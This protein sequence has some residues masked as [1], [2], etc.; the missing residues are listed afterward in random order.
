METINLEVL[1]MSC[2]SCVKH[3]RQALEP[4][5]GVS[6]VQVDL[7]SGHVRVTGALP[8]GA[9]ALVTALSAAGYPSKV[10]LPAE[11]IAL[12]QKSAR[13]CCCG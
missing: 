1:G 10:S 7:Q 5:T 9:E 13:G 4:L 8:Q 2:G 3:V 11:T 12:P 6:D